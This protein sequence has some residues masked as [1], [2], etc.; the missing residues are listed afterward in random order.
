MDIRELSA[1]DLA[2]WLPLWQAYQR[3]YNTDI[4]EKTTRTTWS[5]LTD[6]AEPMFA[7]GAFSKRELVGFAHIIYHR[8]CWTEGNYCY[9]QDL[10]TPEEMRGKGIGTALINA[11]YE[12]AR[13]DGASRVHW[14]THES[15]LA[16]QS[17]YEK[18]AVR[19]GFVQ[20]RKVLSL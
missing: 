20:Y 1:D 13:A 19:S 7:L 16:A 11:V 4:S 14:L 6:P 15:N 17:L 12:R 9:L 8:S 10:F 18:V 5:R 3:F 2:A